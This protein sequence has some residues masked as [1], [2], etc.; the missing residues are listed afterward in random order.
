MCLVAPTARHDPAS[1]FALVAS[2]SLFADRCLVP[3]WEFSIFLQSLRPPPLSG[4]RSVV[5]VSAYCSY[6]YSR[7]IAAEPSRCSTTVQV[8]RRW[9]ILN[10]PGHKR[11]PRKKKAGSAATAADGSAQH[12]TLAGKAGAAAGTNRK[13]APG[14]APAKKPTKRKRKPIS[15]DSESEEGGGASSEESEKDSC[16][17]E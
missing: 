9:D 6:G 14:N 4:R 10:N 2:P 16:E 17:S 12:A 11:A 7:L 13:K 3:C 15:L 1:L 5:H 8:A